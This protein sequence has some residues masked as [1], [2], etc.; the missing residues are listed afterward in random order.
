[1]MIYKRFIPL[2]FLL[3]FSL[4]S[5]EKE[6]STSPPQS[7]LP[8]GYL[9]IDSNPQG[10]KIYAD[11]RNTGRY[12]P[13][14]LNWLETKEYNFTLK[15]ELYR[16]TSF[17]VNVTEGDSLEVFIDYL[18]NPKMLGKIS[19]TSTPNNAKVF[20]NNVYFGRTPAQTDSIVPG[21][22]IVK[23]ERE[24]CRT[25]SLSITVISNHIFDAHLTMIDTTYWV[26]YRTSNSGLTD[27]YI[28]ALLVDRNDV[29]WLGTSFGVDKFDGV[30]WQNYNTTNSPLLDDFVNVIKADADNN[31][32]IGSEGGLQKIDGAGNW[33]AFTSYNKAELPSDGI[34][35]IAFN[36]S[37]GKVF[38]ATRK[39]LARSEPAKWHTYTDSLNGISM[40]GLWMS[41]VDYDR[42][43]K[44]WFVSVNNG[45]GIFDGDKWEGYF[46]TYAPPLVDVSYSCIAHTRTTE[47]FGHI[48]NISQNAVLGLSSYRGGLFNRYTY[49]VFNGL[50]VYNIKI[51]GDEEKWISTDE[52]LYVFTIYS[53]DRI[54]YRMSN[55]GLQTN[56]V[57]GVDFDS[58]GNA[59][60]I[61]YGGG[62]YKFKM[63]KN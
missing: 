47:W 21:N 10:A 63:S 20:L 38:V 4:L 36:S 57:R 51:R 28:Y 14:T 41:G 15:K 61:T 13:D 3:L 53:N 18:K 60:V 31:L 50:K 55:S 46:N 7:P 19:F 29:I 24:N 49:R 39:G 22:Y 33:K 1:M 6:V 44:L 17:N 9:R 16:D 25:D 30:T 56:K 40:E 48:P 2:L 32:W 42:Y 54:V 37:Q 52:G 27:D 12:T 5:C 26:D 34:M 11:G 45:I 35:D 8:V 59:W 58:N 43:G 23:F 62:L